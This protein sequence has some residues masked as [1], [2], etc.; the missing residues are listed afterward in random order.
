MLSTIFK[1]KEISVVTLNLLYQIDK[2][3]YETFKTNILG[4]N[5]GILIARVW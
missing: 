5:I 2:F 3:K 1:F 4:W